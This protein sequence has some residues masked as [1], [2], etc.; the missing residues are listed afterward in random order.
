[1]S[2]TPVGITPTSG[3]CCL[4]IETVQLHYLVG[5]GGALRSLLQPNA[6]PGPDGYTRSSGPNRYADVGAYSHG[7]AGPH[8]FRPVRRA[9]FPALA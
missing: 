1:M 4:H 3:A 2:S 5:V 8:C 9:R 7:S 6:D